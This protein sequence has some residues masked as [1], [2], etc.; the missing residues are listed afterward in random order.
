TAGP[1]SGNAPSL[2]IVTHGRP[3]LANALCNTYTSREP[4]LYIVAARLAY[5]AGA[6]SWRGVSGNVNFLGHEAECSGPGDWS[7]EHIALTDAIAYHE[8]EIFDL[9]LIWILDHY[10]YTSR[11]IDCNDIGGP[12]RRSRVSAYKG[13]APSPGNNVTR[14]GLEMLLFRWHED[15][16]GVKS[17]PHVVGVYGGVWTRIPGG[18]TSKYGAA[19]SALNYFVKDLNL[20]HASIPPILPIEL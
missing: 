18:S 4:R 1:R 17:T 5:H 6:G 12:N 2:N 10:E 3:G 7:Q 20:T 19:T 16:G 8:R 13:Q 9:D 15:R 11:K 14:G